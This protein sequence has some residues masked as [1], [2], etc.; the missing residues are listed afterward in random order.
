[1]QQKPILLHTSK[2]SKTHHIIYVNYNWFSWHSDWR[3]L[4]VVKAA[5]PRLSTYHSALF[6]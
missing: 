6:T 2:R 5:T 1:L 3:W 4:R